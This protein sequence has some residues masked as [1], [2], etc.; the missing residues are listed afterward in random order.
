MPSPFAKYT[1][2][3]IQPIN[4]LRENAEM[5]RMQY[6]TLANL[7]KQIGEGVSGYYQGQRE[8][9][10]AAIFA[11]N[12]LGKYLT[13][14]KE[15]DKNEPEI[16][17]TAPS[18]VRDLWKKS[19]SQPDGLRGVA[20]TDLQA[21]LT[22]QDKF[23][24]ETAV[25]D[26]RKYRRRA[27][28]R[29]EAELT[30]KKNEFEQRKTETRRNYLLAVR[31][32][33][34]KVAN[35]KSQKDIQLSRLLME[36]ALQAAKL[37]LAPQEFELLKAQVEAAKNATSKGGLEL[38]KAQDAYDAE[39]ALLRA[40]Q[41]VP[42]TEDVESVVGQTA[43]FINPEG[44]VE[45]T[46]DLAATLKERGFTMDEIRK[47]EAPVTAVSISNSIARTLTGDNTFDASK[48]AVTNPSSK[49]GEFVKRMYRS[50]LEFRPD[51][52]DEIDKAFRY[53]AET[54][55]L[56]KDV[57]LNKSTYDFAVKFLNAEDFQKWAKEK[58]KIKGGEAIVAPSPVK[59]VDVMW[60]D[61]VYGTTSRL[62]NNF[63]YAMEVYES[64]KSNWES[65][66]EGSTPFPMTFPTMA[67]ALG[68]WGD[69]TPVV[70]PTGI[71]VQS[72]DGKQ[73]M[74]ENEWRGMTQAKPQITSEWQAKEARYNNHLRTMFRVNPETGQLSGEKVGNYELV[75][76][77][78][79][80]NPQNLAAASPAID[81]EKAQQD[82]ID[83]K[84]AL[85]GIDVQVEGLKAMWDEASF[86]EAF[87]FTSEWKNA[88][89]AKQRNLEANFRKLLIAPGTETEKDADRLAVQMAQPSFL[90]LLKD[91]ELAKSILDDT[92]NYILS[93]GKQRL[94][95]YGI[96]IRGG[97][98]Q[99]LSG[100]TA[101]QFMEKYKQFLSKPK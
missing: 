34:E 98:K 72:P 97:D 19:Q 47:T 96:E 60:T 1:G 63:Q 17:E 31:E 41:T 44:E 35:N 11:E 6:E 5:A 94:G 71:M 99:T 87:K 51:K 79:I 38:K 93:R 14:N 88:Y 48:D 70:T 4:Y 57:E 76:T 75:Y 37:S 7:G 32:F 18:H 52:A 12:I 22:L 21:F 20:S 69:W 101:E 78:G 25:E 95:T 8:K 36:Q 50:L 58:Y 62:K 56:N 82:T 43:V 80:N 68:I 55:G 13:V 66:H 90:L 26:E 84:G 33:E 10:K 2:E 23:E 42:R 81:L 92:K 46:E 100:L 53:N 61:D 15:L 40:S 67:K 77:A 85:L 27:D 9:E 59:K 64:A 29:A 49:K 16:S 65:A 54:K 28:A 39:S 3:Q 24:K 73:M 45:W 30:L 83:V 74:T 86:F 89:E 91:S